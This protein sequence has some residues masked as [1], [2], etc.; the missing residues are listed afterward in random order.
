MGNAVEK[1]LENAEYFRSV[2]PEHRRALAE[3][4]TTQEYARRDC[5]FLEGRKGKH[6]Y[7]LESGIVQLL[8]TSADG[9]EIVIKTVG[10]GEV[11]AE[12]VLFEQDRYPVTAVALQKSR[13]H[14]L[15]RNAF[16]ELL[17]DERF[18][19]D[20]IGGLMNRLRYLANRIVYLRAHDV[21]E[22]FFRFLEEQYG[23]KERYTIPMSKKDIAAAIDTT[24]ETLSRLLFRLEQ[25][26]QIAWRGKDLIMRKDFWKETI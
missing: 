22:R 17:E 26:G 23:K 2:S 24:P 6:V 5:L 19:N 8:K 11:F 25:E 7:V 13:A 18:R 14:K 15:P 16:I 20:F 9:R 10:P 21:Q 3:K 12:V 4:C 1:I